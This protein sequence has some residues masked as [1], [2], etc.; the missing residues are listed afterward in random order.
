[1]QTNNLEYMSELLKKAEE[2]NKIGIVPF[3][4]FIILLLYWGYIV[5]FTKVL[6]IY[7]S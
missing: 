3:K 2:D 6:I 4:F 5:P 1:M 7:L